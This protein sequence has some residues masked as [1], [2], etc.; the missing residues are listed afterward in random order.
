MI[1]RLARMGRRA[2]KELES[3]VHP[4]HRGKNAC[5]RAVGAEA[6]DV[7]GGFK[8]G[9]FGAETMLEAAHG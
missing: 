8:R 2:M 4:D 1:R 3:M 5:S 6:G 7:Q 9:Q